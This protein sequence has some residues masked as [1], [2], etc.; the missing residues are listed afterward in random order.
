[1]A[2]DV[3]I[4]DPKLSIYVPVPHVDIPGTCSAC[5]GA[6][7]ARGDDY[8]STCWNCRDIPADGVRVI[9]PVS[10]VHTT[11]SQL[12]AAARDYKSE[13]VAAPIRSA[14]SLLLAATLQRF[15]REHG[16]CIRD[17]AGGDWMTISIIPSTRGRPEPHPLEQTIMRAPALRDHYERLLRW[18][19]EAI[20]HARPNPNAFEAIIGVSGRRILLIDDTF[21]SGANAHSAAAALRAAGGHV[22]ATVPVGRVV[23]T[24]DADRFPEKLEFWKR[25]RRAAFSFGSCCLERPRRA[26]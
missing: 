15:L 19:G 26:T 3:E 13:G 1:M 7:N 17:A 23:D 12:Y 20:D 22:V 24:R 10:L 21:T 8:W 18:T 14:H 2:T 6:A 16:D 5:H 9:V 25:Q 4:T 11:E